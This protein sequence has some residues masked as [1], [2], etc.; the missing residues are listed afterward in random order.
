M[1]NPLDETLDLPSGLQSYYDRIDACVI[2]FRRA[3]ITE[4]KGRYYNEKVIIDV[5]PDGTIKVSN[6][7][8]AP[9]AEEQTAIRAEWVEFS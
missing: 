3:V 6:D 7:R 2:H 5:G 9:T 4:E 1:K 8:Y